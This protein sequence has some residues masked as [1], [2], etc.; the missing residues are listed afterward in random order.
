[1][2][3]RDND[4]LTMAC[5]FFFFISNH[6][7]IKH[8]TPSNTKKRSCFKIFIL[9]YFLYVTLKISLNHSFTKKTIPA[10][11]CLIAKK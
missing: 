11:F 4:I 9:L 1:M 3:V 10:L 6:R 7:K 8:F 2:S 5:Q